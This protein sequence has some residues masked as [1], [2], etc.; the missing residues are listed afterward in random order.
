MPTVR[1]AVAHLPG[2]QV[3]L[4][5]NGRPV[6]ELNFDGTEPN[7]AKTAA[8]SRWRGVDL[9]AGENRLVATVLDAAGAE[10]AVLERTVRY[11]GGG[12]RA[13]LVAEES[14]L[15]A[16]GRTQP[17]IALRVFDAVGRARAARHARRL[18]RRSAVSHLVGS[19]DAA[20]QSAARREQ[21]RADVRRRRRRPR[22][23]SC[24]SRRRKR[25][26]LSCGCA[27]TS[28]K[29]RRSAPG[30]SP[31]SATGSWSASPRARRAYDE[32]DD[33]L[34]PPERSRTRYSSDGRVAF[35]AKGRVKG[36]TL[37][38]I[39]F[40]S[41]RDRPQVED[42]LFGTIEPDRYYTLYGDAVEQRFE[43]ATTR[44]LYLKIERRQFAALFGDFETGFTITELGRYSRSLTGFKADYG[45][46]RFAVNAFAAENRERYGRDELPGDG[47]SGP[48]R[49]SRTAL[50]A[51]SDRLRIEVRDRVRSEVVVESRVLMRFIDYSLDYFTGT[52]TFKQPIPS[53]DA[54]FNPVYVIAEYETLDGDAR[55]HDGRRAHDGAARRR[56]A[57]ARRDADQRRRR[58]R[59]HAA[60]RH[61]PALPAQ[62][63]ARAARRD[64]AERPPT[65]RC[66]RRARR[67]I[68]PRSST[69][70][71]GS[72]CKR[73]C[74]SRTPASAS[75]S[76]CAPRPARARSASTR[77]PR[78]RER[79]TRAR[80]SV[81]ANESADGR[82]PRAR[83]GRS[84]PRDRRRDGERR[85]EARRRRPAAERRAALRAHERGRQPRRA[86]RPRDAARVDRAGAR[87]ALRRASTSPSARRSAST[88]TSRA[89]RRCS[90]RSRMPKAR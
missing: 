86:A 84:A 73:T 6:S 78:S 16:D 13:E 62:R 54:A 88:I 38:T 66:A 32:L 8:L 7:A 64:R 30:S 48:Y 42:R 24:S 29:S 71:S 46:E 35:F 61:G 75:A 51:N 17:V 3:R 22:A 14:Q 58:R 19:R 79:W 20:R 28:A 37:L 67:P 18:S 27:S 26:P 1:V 82:R 36:S 56:Q 85:R 83:L 89:R 47:T 43:A 72:T 74:A 59:R 87:R 63:R 39:A 23:R 60:R 11:G 81:S 65:I 21:P 68:S 33:A 77:A 40:D 41:E 25:A 15:T 50:V 80:R 10:V 90:P 55:R 57:R 12:V 69:S 45:G 53:R 44:K 76:S 5:L 70:R 34:E 49:L 9:V 31:S 4:A 2:Q 52:L